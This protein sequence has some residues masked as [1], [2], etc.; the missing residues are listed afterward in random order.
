ML[1]SIGWLVVVL[2][3]FWPITLAAVILCGMILLAIYWFTRRK[4]RSR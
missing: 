3:W 1:E 2:L 4:A